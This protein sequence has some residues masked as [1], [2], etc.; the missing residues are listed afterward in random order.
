MAELP[1]GQLAVSRKG[2]D[3]GTLY[4]VSGM[5]SKGRVQVIRPPKF[6]TTHPKAKNIR[7]LQ[8]VN[9]NAEEL[10]AIIKAGQDI[11][12]GYFH[13]IVGSFNK[14]QTAAKRT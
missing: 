6:N 7:H 9:G 8:P 5:D 10:A 1:V 2:K 4:V 14:W 12:A 11:D 3:T 13:R